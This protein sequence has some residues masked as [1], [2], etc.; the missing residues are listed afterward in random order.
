MVGNG[1]FLE[2]VFADEY[3][4][5]IKRLIEECAEVFGYVIIVCGILDYVLTGKAGAQSRS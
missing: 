3:F 1:D 4:R 2:A 5:E